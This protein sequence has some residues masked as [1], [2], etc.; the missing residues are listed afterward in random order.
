GIVLALLLVPALVARLPESLPRLADI[1]VDWMVLA[2]VSALALFVGVAVGLIPALGGGRAR[3]YDA[4]RGA[5]RSLGGS[6]HRARATLVVAQVALAL[7][8]VVGATLL[9]RSLNRLLAGNVGFDP[10]HLVT[11]EVQAAGT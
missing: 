5:G 2:L 8:L 1:R 3:L 6:H 4:L 11:M 10:E 7:M 9:G